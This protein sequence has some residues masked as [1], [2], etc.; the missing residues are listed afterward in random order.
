[1]AV[2][3]KE[4]LQLQTIAINC[5][6]EDANYAVANGKNLRILE[7]RRTEL[8]AAWL[9]YQQAF[10]YHQLIVTDEEAC[11]AKQAKC[12][13]RD[14]SDVA[15][16]ELVAL[17]QSKQKT[18]RAVQ[19]NKDKVVD[20]AKS[21]QKLAKELCATKPQDNA[22]ANFSEKPIMESV[23]SSL[24][25]ELVAEDKQDFRVHPLK[26]ELPEVL[27]SLDPGEVIDLRDMLE[28]I[29]IM[30]IEEEK[31]GMLKDMRDCGGLDPGEPVNKVKV[32]KCGPKDKVEKC[33]FKDQ[34]EKF[35]TEDRVEVKEMKQRPHQV[36]EVFAMELK[37][38]NVEV[39]QEMGVEVSKDAQV[40]ELLCDPLFNIKFELLL[41]WLHMSLTL[42]LRF[43]NICKSAFWVKSLI[44]LSDYG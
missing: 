5:A 40:W 11:A 20:V 41:A 10:E 37:E 4:R 18:G 23:C 2:A 25:K 36:G 24:T 15:L 32:E 14:S 29:D 31:Q 28:D 33:S 44:R 42:M 27:I 1:M 13:Q 35:V 43:V 3:A 8:E 34:V 12:L 16:N 39:K 9:G 30:G 38:M 21:V 17:I 19:D 26:Q 6:I 7:K 22:E